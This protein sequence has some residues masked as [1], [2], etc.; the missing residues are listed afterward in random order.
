MSPLVIAAIV[1]GYL[2]VVL[3]GL[4]LCRAASNG[5]RALEERWR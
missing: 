4:G 1:L 3:L 5:D 2:L